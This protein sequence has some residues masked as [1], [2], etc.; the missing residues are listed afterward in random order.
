[1]VV[2]IGDLKQLLRRRQQRQETVGFM[3]KTTAVHVHHAFKYISL[4]S[5][6]RLQGRIQDFF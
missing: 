5:T 6:A 2:L 1:M 3:S 4:T